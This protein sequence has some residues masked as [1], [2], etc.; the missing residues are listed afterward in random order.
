M[1]RVENKTKK[2]KKSA[3]KQ[4]QMKVSRSTNDCKMKKVSVRLGINP[5]ILSSGE[6]YLAELLIC[7]DIFN[8]V[9]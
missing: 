1:V 8:V 3:E 6:Y 4:Q 2:T 7:S 5:V 9:Y